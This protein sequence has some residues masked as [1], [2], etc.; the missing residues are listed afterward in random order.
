MTVAI[1]LARGGSKGLKNKNIINFCGRP[2]ITW[3]INNCFDAGIKHVYV[4]S[5]S[6]KILS[7]S[8]KAGA[9]CII[10][11]KVHAQDYST[12][13]SAWLHALETIESYGVKSEWIIAPQVTSPLRFASDIRKASNL[14]KKTKY[15]S[16]F[17]GCL[18][19]DLLIWHKQGK[20]LSSLNYDWK[21]RKRRQDF[22]SQYVENGSFYMFKSKKFKRNGNRL[23]G[24]I[25]VIEMK[26]WQVF[27]ID[28]HDDME[29]AEI[30]MK[31][32]ILKGKN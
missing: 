11:P 18:F 14:L 2:L 7:I 10:R 26:P 30:L 27:E 5:D 32:F 12:S 22:F 19:E 6:K 31:R 8:K 24:K 23:C 20:K 4:S 17:S 15:D 13:E 25:G 16:F 9:E 28:S 21:K 1:I 29:L 3:T